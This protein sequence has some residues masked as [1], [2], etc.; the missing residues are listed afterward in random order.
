DVMPY[1][2]HIILINYCLPE[3]FIPEQ[4]KRLCSLIEKYKAVNEKI[5][6]STLKT[7]V[8][9]RIIRMDGLEE[10]VDEFERQSTRTLKWITPSYHRIKKELS[11]FL[12]MK[13]KDKDILLKLKEAITYRNHVQILSKLKKQLPEGYRPFE[14]DILLEDA[15]QLMDLPFSLNL[16]QESYIVLKQKLIDILN[17]I[18]RTCTLSLSNYVQQFDQAI[19]PLIEGDIK[20]IA[21]QLKDMVDSIE[22]LEL[23]AERLEVLKQLEEHQMLPFLDQMLLN[24]VSLKKFSTCYEYSFWQA[25]I[26]YMLDHES[27]FKTFSSLGIEKIV[28]EFKELDH[29]HFET[30]KA[31]IVSKLS[32]ARPDESIMIGSRFSI[33]VREYNKS[34]KQKPIRLLLEEIFD[35]I[36]DIK[37]VF[38]MSPLSV[39]TYLNSKL[40]LFD[41]VIFDEA[42]Q[43]FSWDALG[44]IYRAKQCIIIGD[45]KQMPPS[46]FFTTM[47][48]EE[49]GYEND[50]ESILDKGSSVFPTKRLNWHY[51]SRSE[52]LIAFSN[53]NFYDARLITIPQAKPHTQGFGVDFHYVGG[54]YEVKTRIN[55][56]EAEYIVELVF[57][58]V[59]TKPEQ[60]LG[61]VAF[62]TAQAD[63]ISDLIEERLESK[64]DV[65]FFF[66]DEKKEPFFV[67]NLESVQGDERDVILFSICYGY[68]AEHKF[69]QRFGP[70]NALGGER[71][72][73]VAITRAKTNICLVSSIRSSDIRLEQTESI[74][75][76]MLKKYLEYAET[77]STPKMLSNETTDGV[78]AAISS[79]LKKAGFIVQTKVGYSSFKID[80]AVW[81]KQTGAY[82]VAI[83][84]DGPSFQIGNC[85]DA[86]ALQERLL[87]RLGWDFLRVFSTQWVCQQKLEQEHILHFVHNS[88]SGKLV[89]NTT[90][91]QTES[92]LVEIEDQFD[93]S[94][95]SYPYVSDEELKKLYHTKKP[96]EVIRYVIS[97][98]EPIHIDYLL[99]RICFIYG[100]TK[101]TGLVKDLFENDIQDF[102]LFRSD[103]FL[104]THPI[105]PIGL[106]IPSDRTIEYIHP[107]ELKDAIYKV[108]KKSNGISKE[109]CYKKVIG[110][111]GYNRMT[112]RSI[113]ILDQ[114]LV[115]LKLEGKLIEKE[116]CLYV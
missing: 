51:R 89:S 56:K 108:V 110:L 8:D 38:L 111:I 14:Y 86:N 4:R 23:H 84:L 100:R 80:I 40:N 79:F 112:E 115:Y 60:S 7:F 36:L 94:F 103:D 62:S 46:N 67:K 55:R 11:S 59:R 96:K 87:T 15:K 74:G 42:S 64:P 35:L 90:K 78:I 113:Q 25:N 16:T 27:I 3:Y 72:L 104:S 77:I 39:S 37:P 24:Q 99:K 20:A 88:L 10:F 2:D 114:M 83:M 61:V 33:L 57:D 43:V 75:V 45:S 48:E 41:T 6:K 85:N 107:E 5:N 22:L 63:L 95:E 13:M 19:F 58:H 93:S 34:R 21:Y 44:A 106:R 17:Q 70:L 71:R 47:T 98:E 65:R 105:V 30:N 81:D 18:K 49:D 68:T 109:G 69:Y 1:L 32:N 92:Y 116:D 101:V 9:L 66:D 12:K 82:R 54:T 52:E 53:Q 76:M 91:E 28:D 73:N 29:T 50:L 31:Y 102:N 26:L 97:K